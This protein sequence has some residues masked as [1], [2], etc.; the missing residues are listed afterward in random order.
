[1]TALDISWR[2]REMSKAEINQDPMEREFFDEEPIN[3]RLVREAIQNSLDAGIARVSASDGPVRMRFSLAGIHS[4]LPA[5]MAAKYFTGLA[6]HLNAL[7]EPDE[8]IG[9]LAARDDLTR[10]GVRFMVVEDAGTVGLD[11]NW[12]QYDD[13]L[14]ES[15]KDNHFYWFF[16][17]VGRS[18]KGDSDNGSWGLG[19]WVFPD[20]S[21]ASAYI[22]VTRRQS[23]DETLLIG[24]S[25]LS[26]HSMDGR[27]YAPYGFFATFDNEEF[28][29]PLRHSIPEHRS[30]IDGCI[31]DFGLK[32][33][34]EAG[35][36]IIIPFPRIEGDEMHIETPKMI[37][38]IL[39][40][41]FYPIINNRLEIIVDEGDGSLPVEINANTIDDVLDRAS[42][43]EV[44][45]RS[46]KGY[47]SLFALCRRSMQ[48]ADSEYID[49][50]INEIG[51]ISSAPNIAALRRR[52]NTYELLAFRVGTDVEKKN[53]ARESSEFNFYAQRDDSLSE[54]HDYYVRGTLT[55]SEMDLIGQ[56]RARSLLV[57]DENEPLAAMLRDSEPP[58]H[59]AW[60]SQVRRVRDHWVAPQRR[61]NA[62]RSAPRLLLQALQTP[63]ENIQKDAF[64]NIFFYHRPRSQPSAVRTGRTGP[65]R[66]PK[67]TPNP[68]SFVVQDTQSGTGFRVRIDSTAREF[69][70]AARVQVA[71][72]VP[73]GNALKRYQPTDF[74]L[75]GPNAL[76]VV[77]E[78]C[79]TIAPASG[80]NPGNELHVRINEPRQFSLTVQGFDPNRDVYV[81]VDKLEG[82]SAST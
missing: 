47:R 10:G 50:P 7:D 75:H 31:A 33:R 15:A 59:T 62:V 66:P 6:P 51:G 48:L 36:S 60:R 37:A 8:V 12:N 18:G 73:R 81:R 76:Q 44:G 2:F 26:K 22:A 79:E 17:N 55:V 14:S 1:M 23:D 53:G 49:M 71:Y 45:E 54:G 40:N 35:L 82:S 9:V 16:R 11:G 80:V 29:L 61:I 64:A 70:D 42:L 19:K 41:Y 65:G 78:G 56:I 77:M 30:F 21:H 68:R 69:P 20:A 58:A 52:Y 67:V 32:Y 4:P 25:V 72:D 39:H 63:T 24:Q 5:A 74:K 28:S 46:A 43:E 38:A 27:R 34:H 13:S 3:T 57:V